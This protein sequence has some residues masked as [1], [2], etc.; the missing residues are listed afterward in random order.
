MFRTLKHSG[1]TL[2]SK[3][4]RV[5]H[6]LNPLQKGRGARSGLCGAVRDMVN[7]E[8]L[9]KDAIIYATQHGLVYG[10]GPPHPEVGVVHAPLSVLPVIFPRGR[11]VQAKKVMPLFNELIDRVSQ[12]EPFLEETL[13]AAAREDE[14]TARLLQAPCA[15]APLSGLT[16]HSSSPPGPTGTPIGLGDSSF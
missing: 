10:L 5:S 16:R 12:D 3:A 15:L 4:T 2:P 13:A 7:H 14:F 6:S 11:F 8:S 1:H 9:V